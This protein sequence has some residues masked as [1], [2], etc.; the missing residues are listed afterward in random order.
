MSLSRLRLCQIDVASGAN[1]DVI[2]DIIETPFNDEQGSSEAVDKGVDANWIVN[3][4]LQ[5]VIQL[6]LS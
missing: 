6:A 1:R 2:I 5:V 3:H 4:A